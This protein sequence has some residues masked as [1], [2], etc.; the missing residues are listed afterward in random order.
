M[1]SGKE[2][3]LMDNKDI[4]RYHRHNFLDNRS[5][6]QESMSMPI[7][8]TQFVHKVGFDLTASP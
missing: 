1:T 3:D 7:V 8:F 6:N 4:Q 5:L 2:I